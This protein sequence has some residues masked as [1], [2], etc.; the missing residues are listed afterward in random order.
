MGLMQ[1]VM[2]RVDADGSNGRRLSPAL[3]AGTT[4]SAGRTVADRVMAAELGHR[5]EPSEAMSMMVS[6]MV[7]MVQAG[8]AHAAGNRWSAS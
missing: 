2:A 8:K 5:S 3:R 1:P 6:S 7:R 4:A